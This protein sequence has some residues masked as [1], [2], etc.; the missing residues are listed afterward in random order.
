MNENDRLEVVLAANFQQVLAAIN[1]T[2]S[3]LK[4][5]VSLVK[6]VKATFDSGGK[7][8]GFTATAQT[9]KKT[10][11][12]TKSLNTNLNQTRRILNVGFNLG[13][14]YLLWNVTKRI[15]DTIT[16]WI[17]SSVNFI[18]TTNKFEVAMG[19]MADKAYSF[20]RGLSDAFG[21]VTTDMMNFQATFKNI[22]SSLPGLTNEMSEQVSETLVKLGLDYS[23]LYNVNQD[24]AMSRIQAA[25]VG[26]V[27]PIR[28]D[29][30][31]DITEATI[32]MKAQEL[33]IETSVKN[34]NQME[35]RLLRIIVL[36]DQMRNTGAMQDLART[37]EQPANQIKVLKNQI[38]ELGVWLGNVFIGTIGAILPYINGFVMALVAIVKTLAIFV[39]YTNT[40]SGLAEG[41]QE[42]ETAT[43]GIASGVGGAAKSAKELKKTLMGFDVLNVI[44][45]PSESSGGG[46][47]G[48]G[49][50]LGTV[51]PA[52]LNA[53][54]DYDNLMN[55]VKMKAT[56]IRDK[57]MDWLG[58][59]KII[60]PLTGEITW[61]LRDGA[62]RFKTILNILKTA[63]AVIAGIKIIGRLRN[64][65]TLLATGEKTGLKPF[66]SGL[67]GISNGIKA[68]I[69]N[70]SGLSTALMPILKI[71]AG[72]AGLGVSLYGAYDSMRDFSEGTKDTTSSVLEL[73]DSIAGATA[74]GALLGSTI[75]PRN[76][77]FI[78]WNNRIFIGCKSSN[79]R[80]YN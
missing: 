53:L 79:N 14:L 38:Q 48:G 4:N 8:T 74:S 29:A 57:I 51:N 58:F 25:L 1:S 22:M 70:S 66:S 31:Y 10:A 41:L 21:T 23:S 69:S 63:A 45:T 26:S 52:I 55:S 39:G 50:S 3:S 59:T 43:E 6:S 15:R 46:G 49:V 19:N 30:G 27:K 5:T 65:I 37:I 17:E 73:I 28:N 2:N 62:T 33:G 56:E 71:S 78:R 18:E 13:K 20:Q 60:N 47:G 16:G 75:L 80:I 77:N 40:G 42:A 72:V 36:M 64:L 35:K 68:I 67:V 61:K 11:A 54:K 32:G 76:W 34:L 9:M 12:H 24:T 44:Q 7:L